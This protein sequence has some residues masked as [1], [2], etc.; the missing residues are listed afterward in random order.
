MLI[1]LSSQGDNLDA[2]LDPRFGR[3]KYFIFYDT[4]SLSFEYKQNP[5]INASGGAGVQASQYVISK[6]PH[7]IIT[8]SLGPKALALIESSGIK[9]ITNVSGSINHLIKEYGV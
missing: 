2:E 8:G 9:Y 6:N 1:V 5:Y 3:C 4:E 7:A